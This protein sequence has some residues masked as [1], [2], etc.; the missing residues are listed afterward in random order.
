[1]DYTTAAETTVDKVEAM[2]EA[3]D[4]FGMYKFTAQ[5]IRF[6]SL[7]FSEIKEFG[8]ITDLVFM[9]KIFAGVVSIAAIL[10]IFYFLMKFTQLPAE[11][12]ESKESDE[13]GG[14]PEPAHGGMVTGKWKEVMDHLESSNQNEWKL[15]II[16]ADKLV[17]D[18]LKKAGFPGDTMG[19]RLTNTHHDQLR[20]LHYLWQAHRLRNKIVHE[21]DFDLSYRDTHEA[22]NYYKA[23]LEE[24]GVL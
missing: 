3:V 9:L 11:K 1:M 24:L 12:P 5:T 7:S 23:T 14:I 6:S 17:D 13:E 8:F 18:L 22:L 20:T 10:G 21:T 15:A 16:E 19:E 4:F 2:I